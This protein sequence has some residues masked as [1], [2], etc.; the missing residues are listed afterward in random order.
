[1]GRLARLL[2][3]LTY[4]EWKINLRPGEIVEPGKQHRAV[5]SWPPE[6]DS[7]ICDKSKRKRLTNFRNLRNRTAYEVTNFLSF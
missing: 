2:S 3:W 1:M 7:I 5:L 4:V 6:F